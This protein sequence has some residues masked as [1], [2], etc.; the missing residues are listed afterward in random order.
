MQTSA[1]TAGKNAHSL[2]LIAA[3]EVKATEIGSRAHLKLADLQ[4]V[5]TARNRLKH[6]LIVGQSLTSLIHGSYLDRI[7]KNNRTGVRL[8]LP[9]NHLKERRLTGTV[10]AN[11][12]NDGAGWDRKG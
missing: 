4:N 10:G 11:D 7:A 2:L 8:F 1:L 6:S 12:T 3:L 5:E 9:C